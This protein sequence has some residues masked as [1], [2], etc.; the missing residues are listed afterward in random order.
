MR[1]A[2]VSNVIHHLESEDEIQL[3]RKPLYALHIGG[4]KTTLVLF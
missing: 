2:P 3:H 4:V 1:D